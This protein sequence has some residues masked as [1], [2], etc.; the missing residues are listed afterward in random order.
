[1]FTQ[2]Y[3]F[4]KLTHSPQGDPVSPLE[5]EVVQGMELVK[6]GNMT[7]KQIGN[8]IIFAERTSTIGLLKLESF[9]LGG[10]H[11][12]TTNLSV[13]SNHI[14]N[15]VQMKYI[16]SEQKLLVDILAYESSGNLRMRFTPYLFKIDPNDGEIIWRQNLPSQ[17]TVNNER[18]EGNT[19]TQAVY[20]DEAIY[21][22]FYPEG[23]ELKVYK[24][25]SEGETVWRR[26][27]SLNIEHGIEAFGLVP[28]S[29]GGAYLGLY[30]DAVD[31]LT[32]WVREITPDG[33]LEDSLGL[34]NGYI[35]SIERRQGYPLKFEM[36]R[37]QENIWVASRYSYWLARGDTLGFAQGIR[38]DGTLLCGGNGFQPPTQNESFARIIGGI[39]DGAGGLW[40]QYY[41]PST[42]DYYGAPHTIW[43]PPNGD[44]P[45]DPIRLV[46]NSATASLDGYWVMDNGDLVSISN[47]SAE[48]FRHPS[49]T[50]AFRLQRIRHPMELSI[51][52]VSPLPEEFS[53]KA[54]YPNPFNSTTLIKYSAPIAAHI[55]L[56]L[57]N[58]AGREVRTLIEGD[59]KAGTHKFALDAADLP[60]G[61]F[62][63]RMETEGFSQTVK[64]MLIK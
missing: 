62:F 25:S 44:D 46:D 24:Y 37:N 10:N 16:A 20:N 58:L 28:S 49:N 60:S 14:Y 33:E 19:F 30:H 61:I 41:Y 64:L 15:S 52:E 34:L 6:R 35:P 3:S 38:E 50:N 56:R 47:H 57:Y 39:P 22:A 9:D 27:I 23:Y 18:Y 43:I 29:S 4:K 63:A 42:R 2:R 5:G 55:S 59:H 1:L 13:G 26:P 17:S 48:N 36:F 51:P 11:V 8:S 40:L 45:E 53:L 54:A 12:W 7:S 31:S 32:A 21:H